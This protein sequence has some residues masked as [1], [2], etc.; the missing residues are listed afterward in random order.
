MRRALS[1]VVPLALVGVLP[2][3]G[4]TSPTGFAFGRVGGNIRSYSVTIANSGVVHTYGAVQLGRT[5]VSSVQ[6]AGLNRIATETHF[7]I[8][9]A[10]VNC[11]GTLPDVATTYVRVGARTVRVH[12]GCSSR[13]QRMLEALKASVRLLSG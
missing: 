8:L 5:H 2:A 9:P 6:L 4:A 1:F 7:T 13:Y 10:S 3:A 11:R 12:G